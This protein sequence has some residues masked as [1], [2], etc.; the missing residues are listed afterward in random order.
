MLNCASRWMRIATTS[1][2]TSKV[3]KP[4]SR[5]PRPRLPQMDTADQRSR[6]GKGRSQS[7]IPYCIWVFYLFYRSS[8]PPSDHVLPEINFSPSLPSPL[9]L[10]R[11]QLP[12]SLIWKLISDIF[13]V[14]RKL[15]IPPVHYCSALT[16]HLPACPGIRFNCSSRVSSVRERTR[17]V[18]CR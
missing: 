17:A 10:T 7:T 3:C 2:S 15:A 18:L 9:I 5:T 11:C 14:V 12:P 8:A 1:H 13:R 6:S 4:S 16:E